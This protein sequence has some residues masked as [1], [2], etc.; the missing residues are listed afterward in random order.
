MSADIPS[1]LEPRTLSLIADGRSD[2]LSLVPW[3]NGKCL[4]WDFTCPDTLASSNLNTSVSSPGADA[5]KAEAKKIVKYACLEHTYRFIPIA[6]ETLGALG[7]DADNFVRELGRR[8][9]AVSGEK[10]AKA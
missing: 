9:E 10:R 1:K 3:S 5:N 8:I 7:D 4:A 2:G 6:V